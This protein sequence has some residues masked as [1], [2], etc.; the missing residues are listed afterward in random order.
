MDTEL[1]DGVDISPPLLTVNLVTPDADA[2]RRSPLLVLF[3]LNAA[4][5]DIPPETESTDWR[6]PLPPTFTPLTGE[7]VRTVFPFPPAV[8]V[9]SLFPPAAMESAALSVMV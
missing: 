4:V 5:L 7:V 9:R 8:S 3:T 1:T 2:V 6:L